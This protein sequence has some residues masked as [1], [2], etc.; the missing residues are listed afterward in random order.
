M[1]KAEQFRNAVT[2]KMVVVGNSFSLEGMDLSK[3]PCP[4][5]SCNRILRHDTFIPDNLMIA[6]REAYVQERDSGRLAMYAYGVVALMLS[7]TIFDPEIKGRRADK[8]KSREYP[9]Q[10]KPDFDYFSWRVGAWHTKPNFETFNDLLCS[11]ANIF[12]PMLQAAVIMGAREIGVVGVDMMWPSE[13]DSHFYG[14]GKDVG[15]FPFVSVTQTLA[16][17]QKMRRELET[18]GI[19]VWNLSPKKNTPFGRVF[20]HQ[21]YETYTQA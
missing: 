15:A 19:K 11:A 21:D 20:N 17:F 9:A 4:T 3:I 7:E 10:P 2:G 16:T 1:C 5:I 12:G 14:D 18:M 6:D 13:G 8:D